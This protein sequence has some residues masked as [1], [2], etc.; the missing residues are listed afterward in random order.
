MSSGIQL[1]YKKY[2]FRFEHNADIPLIESHNGVEYSRLSPLTNL[3]LNLLTSTQA[4]SNFIICIPSA[5]LKPIPLISYIIAEKTQKSV[6]VFSTTD[7]HHNNY[8]LLKIQYGS[9]FVYMDFPV[10]KIIH[11]DL[12]I[13]PYF[14]W[15]THSFRKEVKKNIPFLLDKFLDGNQ[16]KIMFYKDRDLKISSKM[17]SIRFSNELVNNSFSQTDLNIKNIIF[18]NIDYTIYN[19]YRLDNFLEWITTCM[20]NDNNYIFH[21]SNPNFKFLNILKERFS[22]NLLY[23][24]YSFLKTNETLMKKNHEYFSKISKVRHFDAISKINIDDIHIYQKS[25]ENNFQIQN[26]L[27]KGNIDSFFAKGLN[28]FKTIKWN[29]VQKELS[30]LIFKLKYLYFSIYKLF[31]IPSDFQVKYL[32]N[33]IGWRYYHIDRYLVRVLR[34]INASCLSPNLEILTDIVIYLKKMIDELS[35]CKRY[36]E[37]LSYSRIGKYYSLFDFLNKHQDEKCVIGVQ[38]GEKSL[39]SEKLSYHKF[40]EN[41]RVH[42]F[43]QL[44]HMIYDFSEYTL[45]LPGTLLPNHIQILFKNWKKVLY[46]VYKGNN[47][48][49]VKDQIELINKIDLSKEELTIISLVEVYKKIEGIG[50]Y[51]IERDEMFKNFLKKKR[52]LLESNQSNTQKKEAKDIDQILTAETKLKSVS[53][54]DLCRNLM[55]SDPKFREALIE[56]KTKNFVGTQQKKEVKKFLETS[57]NIDCNVIL[58]NE[59]NG[60]QISFQLDY[61]KK[62]MFF[63][64]K[65]DIKVEISFPHAIP[66]QSYLILFG[67]DERLSMTEFLKQAFEFE[68][69]IDYDLIEKWHGRL[70]S[71][72]NKNYNNYKKFY[73][74]FIHNYPDSISYNEFKEWIKGNVNYTNDPINLYNLGVLM[75]DAFFMDDYYSIHEEGKKI[76]KFNIRLSKKMKKLI[77][78]VLS[79]NITWSS[80]SQ[81]ER[82]L[83]EKIENCIFKVENISIKKK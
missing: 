6:L 67:K 68:D 48:K 26:K 10:A 41:I 61:R 7:Q 30:S 18:E 79:Q 38:T 33:E 63:K 32:D 59:I 82:L 53:I 83:I 58:R 20:K 25:K 24:P 28:M 54:A 35:E 1:W 69:N 34:I 52:I 9:K 43:K 39:T 12:V 71:F 60:E 22:A 45:I 36:S 72:Y 13:E 5:S 78:Q 23:F 51:S 8:Y 81:E 56:E 31:T 77:I 50:D 37:K 21:V 62:Y 64:K 57:E 47:K 80:C 19:Q 4:N 76:Q 27:A 11:K 66:K 65:E 44:A 15:A 42:T 40:G 2:P 75:D 16:P 17:E 74:D 55:K 3:T 46:F 14:P 73:N 49:W 70:S 29:D